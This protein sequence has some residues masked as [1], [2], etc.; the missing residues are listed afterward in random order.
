M[1]ASDPDP[2]TYI[3]HTTAPGE[4]VV[5]AD[6][7]LG[8]RRSALVLALTVF[9]TTTIQVLAQPVAVLIEGQADWNLVLPPPLM[10]S[11]LVLGCALQAA[12]FLLSDRWPGATVLI[13]TA[14]YIGL[15]VG[16]GVPTWLIG[17]YLVIALAL[18]L[19]ATRKSLTIAIVYLVS[20]VVST[21]GVLFVWTSA[22]GLTFNIAVGFVTAEA[23]RI[24]APAIGGTALGAWW[25]RQVRKVNFARIQAEIAEREHGKRVEEAEQRERTRIAQELHDVA[26]Q[27]LAGLITLADAALTIAPTRPE[28]A[29]RLVEE[30]R[31]EGRFAS[32]SL[33]GALA[34]LRAVGTAPREMT[35]DLRQANELF[36]YWH[37]RGMNIRL[38]TSGLMEELPAV[39]STTAYRCTQE[40]IT[41]AAKHAPGSEVDV[42]INARRNRLEVVIVNGPSPSGTPP[43]A[44]LDL[45]WGLSGIRE[46]I[47]LLRG[48]LVF[49][50]TL[51]GG[52]MVRFVIPV[53]QP[54]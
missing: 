46:R 22:Y 47:D 18:F 19:L 1:T 10:L 50:T 8:T 48:T 34:D 38:A 40:A 5:D 54:D 7:I 36:E 28:D 13:S 2:S 17:M 45:G 9:V 44:G 27:H 25:G 20:V 33:A 16:L 29:L 52:W 31:N 42:E 39:V 6:R 35:R 14:V 41:N 53:A 11:V 21:V 26:G 37:K 12:T 15:T 23:I 30:V 24:A 49:G 4:D 3:T 43:I 51:E 32:A